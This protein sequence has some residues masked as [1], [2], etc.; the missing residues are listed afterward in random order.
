MDAHTNTESVREKLLARL[1]E[2]S[3][4]WMVDGPASLSE[5]KLVKLASLARQDPSLAAVAKRANA[6]AGCRSKEVLIDEPFT[7]LRCMINGEALPK[8]QAKAGGATDDPSAPDDAAFDQD[9]E[10]FGGFVTE[11]QEHLTAIE[12]QILSLER[13]PSQLSVVHAVFRAFHTIK[14][15][16]GFLGLH[17]VQAVAHEV[18]TLLDHARN[19]RIKIDEAIVDL[20]LE[21]AE[22]LQGEVKRVNSILAGGAPVLPA[23]NSRLI[24]SITEN[25]QRALQG[26]TAAPALPALLEVKQQGSVDGADTV[27]T[28]QPAPRVTRGCQS[29]VESTAGSGETRSE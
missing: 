7:E 28:A 14:G 1:N 9:P 8:A 24:H 19:E 21:S 6:L 4:A 26:D 13:D 29:H 27:A 22:Y 12:E 16:A 25:T 10:M 5:Q 11:S 15:L 3:T 23:D 17:H 2:L 20:V 18:E